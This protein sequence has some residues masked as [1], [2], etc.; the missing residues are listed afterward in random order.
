MGIRVYIYLYFSS[1]VATQSEKRGGE[2]DGTGK[3]RWLLTELNIRL[4]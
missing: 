3:M 1:L 2:V 4:K